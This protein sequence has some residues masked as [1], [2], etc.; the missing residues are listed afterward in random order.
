MCLFKQAAG[1]NEKKDGFGV[2][3]DSSLSLS[4]LDVSWPVAITAEYGDE[5]IG[6]LETYS[7]RHNSLDL[8]VN[9]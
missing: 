8:L 2:L 1:K 6:V 9:F 5:F 7:W 4:F 3:G